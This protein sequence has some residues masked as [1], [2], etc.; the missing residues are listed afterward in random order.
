VQDWQNGGFGLYLHWPFCAAKCPYCD[1]NSHVA[2]KIDQTR[3]L[4]AYL[5]EIDRVAAQ[6]KD[7]VL[8]TVFFGGGTP[9]LMAPEVVHAILARIRQRWTPA[10]DFEVTLE[11]NPTSVEAGRFRAYAEAGVN[12]LSMGIQALND[13]DLKRLGRMHDVAQGRKA[14]DI[15]RNAFQRVSFDLIY[16]RQDQDLNA[17]KAELR[18]ALAMAVDHFSLYQLTI[19]EGTVFGARAAQGHLKG[20]PSD[21]LSSDMYLITQDICEEFGLPAYEVSNHARPGSESRHN[22]IYWRYGDY[23]GVGPG[24]Y[25]RISLGHHRQATET[26]LA[27]QFWLEQVERTGSGQSL[28]DPLTRSQQADEFLLM[29]LRLA[30]GIDTDRYARIAGRPLNAAKID[31]LQE[32]GMVGHLG[33]RLAATRNGRPVL[34]A[35]LRELMT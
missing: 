4:N 20:L 27:P 7:R 28:C 12:R 3:W 18:E 32:L 16:A 26:P 15:A 35:V 8:N 5:V 34:N 19:E 22:L 17:W 14:F 24:A 6:T 33:N 10:N 30:E 21:D 1:F 2:Q 23:L 11:A 31:M 13:A 9:S 25:G 29:G